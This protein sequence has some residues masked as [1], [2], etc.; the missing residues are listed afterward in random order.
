MQSEENDGV[1]LLLR[2]ENQAGTGEAGL[3]FLEF[4]DVERSNV[5]AAGFEAGA[6]SRKG[7]WKNDC[8]GEG[9][10]VG[11]VGF[12]GINVDPLIAGKSRR[13]EPSAVGEEC[14]AAQGGNG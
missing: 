14:I 9:Q 3:G 13:I 1:T 4:G 10:G 12:G 11:G 6:C 8:V 7:R 5:E 2:L